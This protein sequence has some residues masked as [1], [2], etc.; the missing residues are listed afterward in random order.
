MIA[1]NLAARPFL[2][3]RPVWLVT[4]VAVVL[5]VLF[6]VLNI[7]F[8]FSSNR[9]LAPQIER[10]RELRS[11]RDALAADARAVIDDLVPLLG[12]RTHDIER[13]W[14]AA[15]TDGHQFLKNDN[16]CF[17]FDPPFSP[18]EQLPTQSLAP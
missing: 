6:L 9:T 10:A 13:P 4:G 14:G 8:Y 15:P 3:T 11:Q 18:R 1:P 12:E 7:S 16:Q 2:N 17:Q 5:A